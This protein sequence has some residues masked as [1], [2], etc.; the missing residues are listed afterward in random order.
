MK[1]RN[2]IYKLATLALITLA[3][4]TKP[5]SSCT[6]ATTEAELKI[7]LTSLETRSGTPPST[8]QDNTINTLDIF[9]FRYGEPASPDYQKLDTYR[10]LQGGEMENISI[11]TTTGPKLICIVANDHSNTFSGVTDL[12]EFRKLTT[13]LTDE[14][15]G[16]FTMYG[17]TSA[18]L[19]TTSS[20]SVTLERFVARVAVTSIKTNFSGTPYAGKTLSDIK[21]YLTNV[22]GDKLLYN[23]ASPSASPHILNQG[24]LVGT[25]A[26]STAETNFIYEPITGTIDDSG[27]GTPH[28]FYCYSNATEEISASTKMVL[29]CNLDGVTYYYPIPVNQPGYGY[30]SGNGHYGTKRN[31]SYSYGITITKPGSLD[32]DEPVVP[33]TLELS[34]GIAEWNVIPHFHKE[35]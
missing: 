35:F 8:A 5:C 29:Q 13:S 19:S 2:T 25:D 17:E 20:V 28:W 1:K 26:N 27:D 22:H 16:S 4:C 34:I 10:H 7:E 11:S 23:G 3:S 6:D 30:I 33:G 14:R 24:R 32:P 21:L 15:L 12:T 31:C 9:I 18:I